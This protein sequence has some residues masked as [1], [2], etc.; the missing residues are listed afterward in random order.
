[1]SGQIS[2]LP[3]ATPF[4]GAEHTERLTTDG[5][6]LAVGLIDDTVDL[7]EVVGV[8]DDLVVGD[9]VLEQSSAKYG[10]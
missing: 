2:V 8:G 1:M 4:L 7:L 6:L 9:D 10:Q 5:D 3:Y